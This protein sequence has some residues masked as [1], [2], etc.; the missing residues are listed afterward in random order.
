M[1]I[2]PTAD[3]IEELLKPYIQDKGERRDVVYRILGKFNV[4]SGEIYTKMMEALSSNQELYRLVQ[5][6]QIEA[7]EAQTAFM[8]LITTYSDVIETERQTRAGEAYLNSL[9][10]LETDK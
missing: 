4:L 1:F 9:K 8:Q 10:R 2:G 6:M 5:S 3:S 7:F